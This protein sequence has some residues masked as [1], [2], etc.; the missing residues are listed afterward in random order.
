[1][2]FVHPLHE[3]LL[4]MPGVDLDQRGNVRAN[5]TDYQTSRPN[6][7]SAGDMR[8]GQSLVVWAIREGRLCARLRRVNA[9]S[10]PYAVMPRESGAPSIPET[11]HVSTAVSGMLHRPIPP[12]PKASAEPQSQ[13]LAGAL[14]K[15]ASRAMTPSEER[16]PDERSDIRDDFA[17]VRPACRGLRRW[18]ASLRW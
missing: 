11:S 18:I 6:A 2:G 10:C 1:M 7:F 15:A 14:A 13:G 8:R 17:N 4:N 5:M 16:I 9:A 12:T 3:G